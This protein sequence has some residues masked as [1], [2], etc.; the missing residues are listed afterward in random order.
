MATLQIQQGDTLS[1]I[2]QAQ[3]TTVD[4]LLQANPQIQ[5]PNLIVA[6]EDLNLP[7]MQSP[8]SGLQDVV[9]P[10]PEEIN[11]A[12][13]QSQLISG[14]P[15]RDV[16]AD[17]LLETTSTELEQTISKDLATRKDTVLKEIELLNQNI[18]ER[19]TLLGDEISNFESRNEV[20]NK[21]R[22]LQNIQA[23]EDALKRV[24]REMNDAYIA[25]QSNLK[26]AGGRTTR[27]F[28]ARANEVKEQYN[29]Q[30]VALSSKAALLQDDLERADRLV[31]QGFENII[32]D[33]EDRINNINFL[34]QMDKEDKISL[35]TEERQLASE[36]RALLLQ[37]NERQQNEKDAIRQLMLDDV[38]SAVWGRAGVNMNM[39]LDEI[40]TKLQP[41]IAQEQTRRFNA[42]HGGGTVDTSSGTY[43]V[44]DFK[45]AGILVEVADG[46]WDYNVDALDAFYSNA[47]ISSSDRNKIYNAVIEA[48]NNL[49]SQ[50]GNIEDV[51]NEAEGFSYNIFGPT[52]VDTLRRRQQISEDIRTTEINPD[53]QFNLDIAGQTPATGG[54]T[55]A[56][57]LFGEE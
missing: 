20:L 45:G 31:Q 22:E 47:G 36:Q 15:Q 42:I 39:P 46:V 55:T 14:Q 16:L 5:D 19:Q 4:A 11:P 10:A 56:D 8:T 54:Q 30:I 26:N 53:F 49:N 24:Q 23:K 43:G 25:Y 34:L 9:E 6:G 48:K 41:Y 3:G 35:S 52:S 27:V 13:G 7:Q 44:D 32:A 18:S 38:V 33:R 37:A 1:G 51:I 50:S 57:I 28:N 21:Q 40:M 17:K 12:E 2:A 29:A